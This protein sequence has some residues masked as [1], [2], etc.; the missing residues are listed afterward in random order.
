LLFFGF[1][2]QVGFHFGFTNLSLLFFN[3]DL[4]VVFVLF[5]AGLLTCSNAKTG[6]TIFSRQRLNTGGGRFY[7]SPWAYNGKLFLLNED[8][9]TWVVEDGP[10]F[11]VVRKNSLHDNDYAWA[12]PA[13]ARGS[14]FIRTY[15]GLY[16][17]QNSKDAKQGR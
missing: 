13:I 4:G 12:T 15:T 16:R 9:T 5:D 8:G 3:G 2:C 1:H 14:L 7:A 17:L 11:K 6:E 10:E